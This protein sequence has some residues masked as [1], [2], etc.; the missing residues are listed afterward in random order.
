MSDEAMVSPAGAED[1]GRGSVPARAL[2]IAG[3]D[4]GGG[5]GIQGDLKTFQEL[6]VFGMSVVTA[7][8]AQ[9][10][11]GVQRADPVS[12]RLIAAQLESVL[13]DLGA[14][15]A[16]TGMMPTLDAAEVVAGALRR[17]G[18]RRLVVDPVRQSKDG[19]ALA[20]RGAFEATARLLFPLAELATPN[21]PEAAALLGVREPELALLGERVDAA[22][23][24]LAW[25][26]RYVLLK[27]GHAADDACADIL[28]SAA[29]GG[30]EPL[31]LRGR[32]LPGASAR[33]T[34]CAF[35]AAACAS[36]ALGRD[37]PTACR[38][39]K[40]FVAAAL[41]ARLP[42]G[43]GTASLKHAAWRDG[44]LPAEASIS[45]GR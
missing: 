21:V 13:A 35:A 3:S 31:L 10:S 11:L 12:P 22:R 32:R 8:T 33:G 15:A 4:C 38:D 20:D 19:Y 5:A 36:M 44:R 45:D 40:S 26:S 2:T 41:A 23:S 24:L 39:A 42:L 25:G 17:F 16:K 1:R 30:A 37:V 34:G 7:V 6:G 27:G 29:D 9:N 14:D 18:V 28:V 43:A